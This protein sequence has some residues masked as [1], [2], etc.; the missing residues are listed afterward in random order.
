MADIYDCAGYATKA[1]IL[2]TDGRTIL[3][4]AFKENH[5]GKVPLVWQHMHS[6]PEN[7]L[8]H[9]I[10][11]NRQDGVYAYCKF[12]ETAAGKN[13]KMLVQHGD[14]EALSIYANKLIQDGKNV[15]HGLIREVSL[16]MV[17]AN[18][19]AMIEALTIAHADGS[20]TDIEDEAIIY[21]DAEPP[22]MPEIKTEESPVATPTKLE[23]ASTDATPADSGDMTLGEIFDTLTDIQ[24]ETVYAII[25]EITDAT[26]SDNTATHSDEGDE[27][28]MKKN[29]FD[30]SG[31]ENSMPTRATLS[32]ADFEAITLDAARFGSFKQAFLAH[33]DPQTYGIENIDYLFPDA[34]TIASN[35]A[36]ISRRMEWVQDVINATNKSPFSRIKSVAADITADE[37]RARGYVKG[38]EKKDEVIRLLRRITTPKTIYKKQKL[39]R[40]DIIDIVDL[41]II[42]WMKVEMRVMLDE[43]LA[44]AILVGDG[45]AEGTDDKID[46]DHLRPIWTD[47]DIYAH[48]VRIA[49]AATTTDKID[50]MIRAR[51]FYFGSGNPVLYTS[52]GFVSDAILLKDTLGRRMYNTQL[53][54]ENVLR[55]SK[56][57]EVPPFTGLERESD[58]V[59]P[60]NLHLLGIIVNLKDYT[61]GADKGGAVSMFDNFDIDFNQYRYLLETRVAGALTLPKS[62]LVFE[63]IGT[64][65]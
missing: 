41:D 30:N 58:D 37:A 63:Q 33:V 19:G 20:E 43:E 21:N 47:D 50:A 11:E 35:P 28:E 32:H 24:K 51:E 12:N 27:T 16:V 52:T 23:H 34:R 39:D 31:V 18:P 1:N 48:H 42:A 45:R 7:V 5:K 57:V 40:D 36:M 4:N 2:C 9:A 25:A 46:A 59:I 29:L 8:G 38:T 64:A 17:G 56:I 22:T 10:L 65:G 3:P 61:L 60:V 26:A 15:V 13:A 54:L 14:I 49:N 62:A 55:V 53:E 6:D 44:R